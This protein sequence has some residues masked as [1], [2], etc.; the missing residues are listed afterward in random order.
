MRSYIQIAR[1]TAGVARRNSLAALLTTLMLLTA[2]GAPEVVGVVP[3]NVQPVEAVATRQVIYVT[4]TPQPT[5]IPT[6]VHVTA[7]STPPPTR[8]PSAT[9][10]R[11][12]L[13]AQCD[14]ILRG[15]YTA[16]GE[17]CL[18]QPSGFLCNGGH[19]PKVEPAN[20]TSSIALAGSLVE[21]QSVDWI[22][23]APLLTNNSGGLMYLHLEDEIQMNAMLLGDVELRDVT[24]PGLNL[25]KWQSMTVRTRHPDRGVCA[26]LPYS[27]FVV[28][29]QYG[30]PSRLVIN[31]VSIDLNGTLVVQTH[32]LGES[33]RAAFIMIEGQARFLV[34]GQERVVYAGQQ[35]DVTYVDD[36]FMQPQN[37]PSGAQPLTPSMIANLPI[38]I[39]DRPVLLP[40]P[41]YVTASGNVNM[42]AEPDADSRLLYQVPAGTVMSVLGRT[43]EG[44]WLHVRLGN[45]ETGWMFAELLGGEPGVVRAVYEATPV[46]PQRYGKLGRTGVVNVSAGSNLRTA[47]DATFP[48]VLT[49]PR[50]TEVELLA[51]SAYSP[52]VKVRTGNT[53]GWVALFTLDTRATIR[54]LPVDYDAPLPARPTA[55]PDFGFGGGHAYPDPRG[56]Y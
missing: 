22:N 32:D 31:G 41:G 19:P 1:F 9:P 4:P 23:S 49:L 21:A 36:A 37:I 3:L 5:G 55:T 39:L 18:G 56:G 13:D 24:P 46:P 26:G 15:L 50:G 29:G 40:E 35:L 45:G 2:C 17:A 14:N 42:R 28:Q 54:F 52:W 12:A 10:D 30:V 44:D 47:P 51:R 11:V 27:A 7:T 53:E 20:L 8:P 16:A 6:F 43:A 33:L 38:V 25:P 48:V 34:F